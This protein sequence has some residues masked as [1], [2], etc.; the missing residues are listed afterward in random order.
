[1]DA[2]LE[3][4]LLRRAIHTFQ[5]HWAGNDFIGDYVPVCRRARVTSPKQLQTELNIAWAIVLPADGSESGVTKLHGGDSENRVI[6]RVEHFAAEL[7]AHALF[8]G[9][10]LVQ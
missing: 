10:I 2:G 4:H 1:M 6:H 9:E 8:D 5:V 7:H 3:P